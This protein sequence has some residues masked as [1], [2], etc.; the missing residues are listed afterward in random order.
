MLIKTEAIILNSLKH[1]D[2][3]TIVNCY[4]KHFGRISFAVFCTHGKKS[5]VRTAHLQPLSVVEIDVMHVPGRDMQ[6]IKDLKMDFTFSSIPFDPVKSALALF[7]AEMLSKVL[8]QPDED[9]ILFNFL[10]DSVKYL[11]KENQNLAD[12]HLIF[13]LK[14]TQYLGFYP[15]YDSNEIKYFDLMNGVFEL[16]KPSH[17]HFLSD[18]YALLFFSL[19]NSDYNETGHLNIGRNTRKILLKAI[20]DYYRLHV[21]DFHGLKSL[22]VFQSLFD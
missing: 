20:L 19:L 5:A 10:L 7:L 22:A 12:F 17:T 21:S 9:D 8:R 14:L 13:L 1:S 11:D 3:T 15:N 2:K 18:D 16:H 4:T 6:R